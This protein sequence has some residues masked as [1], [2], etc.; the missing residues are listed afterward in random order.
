MP[1]HLMSVENHS[2]F[3]FF[4]L[5]GVFVFVCVHTVIYTSGFGLTS[6]GLKTRFKHFQVHKNDNQYN[7]VILF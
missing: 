6:T 3:F 1:A 4:L 5:L 7:K 2:A